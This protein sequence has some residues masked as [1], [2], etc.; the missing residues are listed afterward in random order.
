[1]TSATPP[2]AVTMTPTSA[3]S[4]PTRYGHAN[5]MIRLPMGDAQHAGPEPRGDRRGP[6]A[7]GQHREQAEHDEAMGRAGHAPAVEIATDPG[8]PD[9]DRRPGSR[10]PSIDITAPTT[11][12]QPEISIN[13]PRRDGSTTTWKPGH[14]GLRRSRHRDIRADAHE[15]LRRGRPGRHEHRLGRGREAL[16]G[17][18]RGRRLGLRQPRCADMDVR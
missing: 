13:A 11:T 8:G 14:R 16:S 15:P 9:H 7:E 1:M 4:R 10:N 3:P 12:N 17:R 6:D 5:P 18:G 2:S